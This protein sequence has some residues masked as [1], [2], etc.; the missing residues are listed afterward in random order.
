[1]KYSKGWKYRVE[2]EAVFTLLTPLTLR[3]SYDAGHWAIDA[4]ARTLTLR[5]G[6]AWNGADFFPDFNWIKT[7]SAGHDALLQAIAHGVIPEG[8]NDLVDK[9]FSLWVASTPSKW[10]GLFKLR[11]WYT[12]KGTNLAHTAIGERPKVYSL[13]VLPNE[14]PGKT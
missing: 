9:E 12:R 7:P 14:S 10:R 5:V 6:Y 3:I 11:G 4:V 1:M 8:E 13:P 2:E